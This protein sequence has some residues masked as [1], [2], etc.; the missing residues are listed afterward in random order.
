MAVAD[1][2]AIF[3]CTPDAFASAGEPFLL[4]PW[5]YRGITMPKTGTGKERE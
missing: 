4:L 1:G 3:R 5:H 2:E